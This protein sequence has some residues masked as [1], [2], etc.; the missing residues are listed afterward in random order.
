V[1]DGTT[2]QTTNAMHVSMAKSRITMSFAWSMS[3]LPV[4][5]AT[6]FGPK[7][8]ADAPLNK[9]LHFDGQQL[10]P[11][12]QERTIDHRAASGTLGSPDTFAALVTSG[13]F[14]KQRRSLRRA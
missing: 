5:V 8:P 2:D 4:A 12:H 6:A 13:R 14:G 10:R 9:P 11:H 1:K 3:S 7:V